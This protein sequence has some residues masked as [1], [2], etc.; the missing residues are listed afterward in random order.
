MDDYRELTPEDRQIVDRLRSLPPD[1]VT[2]MS[3]PPG[4]WDRI[5][6]SLEADS[7]ASAHDTAPSADVPPARRFD[8]RALLAAA[9]AGIALGAGIGMFGRG[10]VDRRPSEAVRT[11]ELRTLTTN[12]L[13]GAAVLRRSGDN[14]FLQILAQEPIEFAAGYVE[15]WLINLDAERMVSIGIYQGQPDEHFP[16]PRE[17]IEQGFVLVDLSRELLDSDATHSGDSIVR[18]EL[19]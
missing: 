3:P 14:L 9:A 11:A 1:P 6:Q 10:V 12:D 16:V 4:V 19:V 8:R 7:D 2:W 5:A 15:V 17:V 18:G 13:L